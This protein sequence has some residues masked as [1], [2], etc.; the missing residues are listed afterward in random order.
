MT[1]CFLVSFFH[2]KSSPAF[3]D[4][5]MLCIDERKEWKQGQILPD[6]PPSAVPEHVC[7]Q[8]SALCSNYSNHACGTRL[9]QRGVLSNHWGPDQPAL[10]GV[11]LICVCI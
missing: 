9:D 7:K 1:F 2:H 6:I 4:L 8:I 3:H 5:N 10:G 11:F